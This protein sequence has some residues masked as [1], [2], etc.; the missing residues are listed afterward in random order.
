MLHEAN[1]TYYRISLNE[2]ECNIIRLT[3]VKVQCCD[4]L[5]MESTTAAIMVVVSSHATMMEMGTNCGARA[6]QR[7]KQQAESKCIRVKLRQ[8]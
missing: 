1:E 3:N 2:A 8:P 4:T 6:G 7:P 5:P